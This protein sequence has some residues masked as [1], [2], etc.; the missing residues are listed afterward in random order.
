MTLME[1]FTVERQIQ[2]IKQ[3]LFCDCGIYGS[4]KLTV[5]K[6]PIMLAP[7]VCFLL[8]AIFFRPA[9]GAD[10]RF[11]LFDPESRILVSRS[12]EALIWRN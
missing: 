2:A 7:D 11:P 8:L 10:I 5:D 1:R 4:R 3:A 9:P 12:F 6:N